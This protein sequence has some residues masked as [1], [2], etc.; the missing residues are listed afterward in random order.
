MHLGA[1]PE[2][3]TLLGLNSNLTGHG[4]LGSTQPVHPPKQQSYQACLRPGLQDA[5]GG[6]VEASPLQANC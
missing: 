2:N 1:T 5:L 4:A 6:R 3:L